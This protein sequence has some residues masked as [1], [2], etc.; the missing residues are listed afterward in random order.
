MC[1]QT[2]ELLINM[3]MTPNSISPDLRAVLHMLTGSFLSD[4][5]PAQKNPQTPIYLN[6]I[7]LSSIALTQIL[8]TLV[9]GLISSILL[10]VLYMSYVFLI[11]Q[12]LHYSLPLCLFSFIIYHSDSLL[13]SYSI[14]FFK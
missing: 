10:F 7:S 13:I 4:S 5:P 2:L 14:Y 3:L 6:G 9:T 11:S 12:F 8:Q 1:S